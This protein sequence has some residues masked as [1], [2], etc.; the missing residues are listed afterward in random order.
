MH[1]HE[2]EQ[3][4]N[5]LEGRMRFEVGGQERIISTGELLH[6][7]PG[8]PHMAEALEDTVCLDVF[9]PIREDW[10]R[11]DDAYLRG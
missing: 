2:N 6:I 3:M 5:V 1:S 9:D 4:S 8:V 7:P 11:G 10:L